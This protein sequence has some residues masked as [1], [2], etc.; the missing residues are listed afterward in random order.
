[1]K[2]VM[3]LV[4]LKFQVIFFLKYCL[5]IIL[6]LS[7]ILRGSLLHDIVL[8]LCRR[9][10][11]NTIQKKNI[12]EEENK[13]EMKSGNLHLHQLGMIVIIY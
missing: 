7:L 9:K 3:K 11:E 12:N 6:I 5:V 8:T 4:D 10:D 13:V 2:L 1:M